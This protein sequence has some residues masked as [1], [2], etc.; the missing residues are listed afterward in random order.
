MN[1]CSF[2]VGM[3][4]LQY[5]RITIL[6]GLVVVVLDHVLR[7]SRMQV[8]DRIEV[9]SDMLSEYHVRV[10]VQIETFLSLLER[11]AFLITVDW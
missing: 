9:L 6:K 4:V 5:A 10:R 7:L 2:L 8:G 1:Q 11:L 3:Q